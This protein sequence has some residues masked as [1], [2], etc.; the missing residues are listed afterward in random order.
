MRAG[1]PDSIPDPNKL[2]GTAKKEEEKKVGS[3]TGRQL[4]QGPLGEASL[5]EDTSKSSWKNMTA[6]AKRP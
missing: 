5:R 6:C 3:S 2:H 1:G 4:R